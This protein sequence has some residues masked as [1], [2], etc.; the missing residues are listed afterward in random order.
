MSILADITECDKPGR[1]VKT[2][3]SFADEAR[4]IGLVDVDVA[5]EPA[6]GPESDP[7]AT[8]GLVAVVGALPGELGTGGTVPCAISDIE[9]AFY[10]DEGDLAVGGALEG[11][12]ELHGQRGRTALVAYG[13][14]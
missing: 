14:T 7:T 12:G 6:C 10:R 4:V 11:E 5:D 8:A 1:P 13:T 2:S 3:V 9:K